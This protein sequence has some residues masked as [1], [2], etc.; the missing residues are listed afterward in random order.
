MR[1]P[2]LQRPGTTLRNAMALTLVL[3]PVLAVGDS[4][5]HA[6]GLRGLP[7]WPEVGRTWQFLGGLIWVLAASQPLIPVRQ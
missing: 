7:W 5:A 3:P 1:A 4:T 6:L 2:S